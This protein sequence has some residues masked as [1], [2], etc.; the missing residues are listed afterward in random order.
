[1]TVTLGALNGA[2]KGFTTPAFDA[3]LARGSDSLDLSILVYADRQAMG[4]D[5]ELTVGESPVPKEG[6]VLPG[7]IS[8]W[9]ND[10][11]AVV[12]R[13]SVGDIAS[14]AL[15]AFLSLGEPITAGEPKLVFIRQPESLFPVHGV[16]WMAN[17]DGSEQEQLTPDGVQATF[18][19]LI[20]ERKSGNL[21][22]YYVTRD[23]ETAR[24]L[25]SLN[26]D[27]GERSSVFTFEAYGA[28]AAVSPDGRYAAYVHTTGIGLLD[29]RTGE[30][31]PML[32]AGSHDACQA[33]TISEC[34]GYFSPA[35]SPD[36]R[37]LLVGKGFYEGSTAVVVDPFQD[38]P[39]ELVESS[40]GDTLPSVGAWSP[41]SDA[42]CGYGQ[43]AAQS[44]LYL[45]S[46]PDWQPSN[47]L[48][49]YEIY[50]ATDPRY[51]GRTVTGCAWVDDRRIIFSST[52]T[53]QPA[54]A[55]IAVFDVGAGEV[56]TIAT[57]NDDEQLFTRSLVGAPGGQFVVTQFTHGPDPGQASQPVRVDVSSGAR[58]PILE[59]G[60][61]VVAV[62]EP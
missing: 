42:F 50:D 8:T 10:N 54:Q 9:W 58:Q 21:M 55:E 20:P 62:V 11:V 25:W 57:F 23:G 37:L 39:L 51:V 13:T 32:A 60:D 49:E 48:P 4:E 45:A 47:L 3:R 46:A 59:E 38:P 18:A 5:W 33:G 29:L 30:S 12:A 35:W 28:S 17:L 22:F 36:G 16:L 61:W 44:G 19:G 31:L 41:G 24:T 14:D 56:S 40:L 15:D 34:V 7:H 52:S 6:R 43:Y 53:G 2:F 1:M 27:S 26:A